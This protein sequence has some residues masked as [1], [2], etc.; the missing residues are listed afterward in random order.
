MI[1]LIGAPPVASDIRVT[2]RRRDEAVR[3]DRDPVRRA[4]SSSGK[5]VPPVTSSTGS[6]LRG[7]DALAGLVQAPRPACAARTA[8]S[9]RA[10]AARRMTSRTPP[11][12]KPRTRTTAARPAVSRN[13]PGSPATSD[14]PE[15]LAGSSAKTAAHRN[16]A[17]SGSV[18]RLLRPDS[19]RHMSV[20][21]A[22]QRRV[23]TGDDTR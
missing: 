2:L 23:V 16:P 20:T 21:T 8:F 22:A 9:A 4:R 12:P 14:R 13:R 15:G 17:A 10:S 7:A 6:E 5:P 3:A 11:S 1:G 19:V 18:N